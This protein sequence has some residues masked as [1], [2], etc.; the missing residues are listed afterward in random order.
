MSLLTSFE[1]LYDEAKRTKSIRYFTVFCRIILA[2]GFIP[3]GIV[4]V[5]GERFTALP[6][7][8][9]LGHYFDAL[10]LTRY[11]YTF[12][13]VGQL[14]AALL[15]LIPRTALLGAI[16]YFPII[17]NI[18]V[19]ASAT[20]FNG[21]RLTTLMLLANLFLLVWD[22]D[23]LKH[24]LAPRRAVENHHVT[25]RSSKL[26][27][28]FF[29]F[30]LAAVVS[31][32][33]IDDFLYPIRPGNERAECDNGC[34]NRGI[35]CKSFCDCIYDDGNPLNRCLDEYRKAE[36]HADARTVR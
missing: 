3:A 18:W 31:V 5:T 28:W 13:G 12:I 27:V 20:R 6:S 35:A 26:P 7:T 24:L 25:V 36:D 17:L 10:F 21:T 14:T 19:L 2:A 32:I 16:V 30:V 4:K 29:G 22:H 8:N 1:Q 23:R 34:R 9:P 15:L 11:Y 33:A